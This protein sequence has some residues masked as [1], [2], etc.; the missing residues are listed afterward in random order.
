MT[1]RFSLRFRLTHEL[2]FAGANGPFCRNGLS[3]AIEI[4]LAHWPGPTRRR[5][6]QGES[7]R[8]SW[9]PRTGW[10]TRHDCVRGLVRSLSRRRLWWIANSRSTR[11]IA[12]R[13]QSCGVIHFFEGAVYLGDQPLESHLGKYPVMPQS[14]GICWHKWAIPPGGGCSQ[15]WQ[16]RPSACPDQLAVA[17]SK[18]KLSPSQPTGA[19]LVDGSDWNHNSFADQTPGWKRVE[20]Q[21]LFRPGVIV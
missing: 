21:V 3:Q 10:L 1:S 20:F 4:S 18:V 13:C 19:H 6:F 9:T 17:L 16:H 5:S 14:S 15:G 2:A 11:T 8:L 12:A 7:L